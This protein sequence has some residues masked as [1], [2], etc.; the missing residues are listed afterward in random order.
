MSN[1]VNITPESVE[2]QRQELLEEKKAFRPKVE[3]NEKN[4]LN[5][6]VGPGELEKNVTIRILPVSATDGRAFFTINTHSLKV[7]QD[8]SKSGFKSFICL[9]DPNVNEDGETGVC[10]LCKKSKELYAMADSCTD[11]F[12]KKDLLRS[13]GQHRAKRTFIVRV[14]DRDHEDE[15]VK[16]WRFNEHRDGQ[17]MYDQLM[18]LYTIRNNE[19]IKSGNGPFNIFDLHNGKDMVI[20]LRYDP[21]NKKTS[22]SITDSGFVSPLSTSEEQIEAWVGDTKTWKDIYASKSV[23][24]LSIIADGK[25][26]YYDKTEG[27]WVAKDSQDEARQPNAFAQQ[28]ESAAV[29]NEPFEPKGYVSDEDDNDLPF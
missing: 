25:V 14:I 2:G 9:D 8:I 22:T 28:T 1:Y 17:G 18:K 16:F 20:S 10:P 6:R 15:G 12:E 23:E 21:V 7:S 27:V 29:K 3:F 4:Y 5:L 26:P 13:A 11:E 19:S 24:Y